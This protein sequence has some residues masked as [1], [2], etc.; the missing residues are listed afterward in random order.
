MKQYPIEQSDIDKAIEKAKMRKEAQASPVKS[1]FVTRKSKP[2]S[3]SKQREINRKWL[4]SRRR[5]LTLDEA[6]ARLNNDEVYAKASKG[7]SDKD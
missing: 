2:V 7:F 5:P 1:A 3:K 6:A 4:E